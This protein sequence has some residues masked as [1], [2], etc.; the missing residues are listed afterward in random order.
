LSLVPRVDLGP[1]ARYDRD[2]SRYHKGVYTR[3]RADLVSVIDSTLS[4][5][6]LGQLKNL[7]KLAVVAFKQDLLNGL[8]GD[9]Y[10]FAEVVTK[11]TKKC[12]ETFS[13]GAKEAL[14][15]GTDWNWEDELEVIKEEIRGVADQ[16]RK[17][18]TK[19]MI[20]QIEV[21]PAL[22]TLGDVVNRQPLQRNVKKIISEPVEI[23]LSKPSSEMW[24]SVLTTFKETLA[25]AEATYLAKAKSKLDDPSYFDFPY[26]I[27]WQA[28]TA[29]S[30]R[31]LPP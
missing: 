17:D 2:A 26:L 1:T 13:T 30:R 14:V 22:I 20:N 15:E 4:P 21:C 12:E 11:A 24:D 27:N 7:H 18:E 6:F 3:K 28:S 8:K 29:P 10:D 31:T 9:N 16:C 19:K 23:Q 5:L 25:K